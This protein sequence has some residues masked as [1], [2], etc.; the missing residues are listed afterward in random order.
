MA[1]RNYNAEDNE[2]KLRF[3]NRTDLDA[4]V[5]SH[6]IRDA[7]LNVAILFRHKELEA[8]AAGT[9]SVPVAAD[10]WLPLSV[11]DIW[12]PTFLRNDTDGTVMWPTSQEKIER[13]ATKPT[14]P[15]RKFYW[16]GGF[17]IFDSFTNTSKLLRVFYKRK[18]LEGVF[19]GGGFSEMDEIFDPLIIM[20]AA[21]VG[22]ETVR[23]FDQA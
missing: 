11:V 4:T 2:V 22:L 7:Y 12:F 8:F 18:P 6:F 17:F 3:G 19:T 23:D 5:R 15:P 21:R 13:I 16:Y 9:E 10:R 14:A 1:R 20:D